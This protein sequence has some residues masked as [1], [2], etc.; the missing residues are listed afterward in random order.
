MAVADAASIPWQSIFFLQVGQVAP[1][2]L[3]A[4]KAATNQR[5]DD[6]YSIPSP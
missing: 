1:G 2:L 6:G 4:G 5:N 3:E